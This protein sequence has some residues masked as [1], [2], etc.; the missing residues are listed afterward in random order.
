MSS[1]SVASIALP[2]ADAN[3]PFFISYLRLS[4]VWEKKLCIMLFAPPSARCV[5]LRE[6]CYRHRC[7]R[8]EVQTGHARVGCE[9]LCFFMK[10]S[11]CCYGHSPCTGSAR[12]T[13]ET[14]R[15]QDDMGIYERAET[16]ARC[17]VMAP[18]RPDIMLRHG[19]RERV[20]RNILLEIL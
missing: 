2:L 16:T 19:W 15:A 18:V 6:S 14:S 17:Q 3:H 11:L 8:E 4:K 9:L 13:Y 10:T 12:I 20:I 5:V 7:C 1:V